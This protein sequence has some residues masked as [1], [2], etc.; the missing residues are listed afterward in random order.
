MTGTSTAS[1]PRPGAQPGG[2]TEK[3]SYD[4]M[5]VFE[6]SSSIK[7]GNWRHRV[8]HAIAREMCRTNK[9]KKQPVHFL[10]GKKGR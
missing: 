7:S 10:L 9:V 1:S 8:G 4:L 5:R 3:M 2:R 6:G